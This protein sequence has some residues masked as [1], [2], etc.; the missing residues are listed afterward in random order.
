M[1]I[2]V[3][4]PHHGDVK[5]KFAQSLAL[6]F[7]HAASNLSGHLH[8]LFA[9]GHLPDVRNELVQGALSFGA[10]WILWLD[11][12][13]SFPMNTLGRLLAHDLDVVGC[14]YPRRLVHGPTAAKDGQPLLT[15]DELVRAGA[16]DE[17]D[18]LGLGV[19]LTRARVFAA[20]ARPWFTIEPK[21]DGSGHVSED[22]LF[23]RR[24]KAA[25][26]AAHVDHALSWDIGHV[27]EHTLTNQELRRGHATAIL[28]SARHQQRRHDVRG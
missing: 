13:H 4:V 5:A 21:E 6:L 27:T 2:A 8:L 20:I 18:S 26:I 15:T 12:D 9:T 7:G 10:D 19:C 24:L 25:G 11:S 14:N 23:F 3:C 1:K 28:P 17:V 16:V 22:V